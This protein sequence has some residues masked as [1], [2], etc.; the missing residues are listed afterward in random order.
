MPI[1]QLD[2]F[3]FVPYLSARKNLE[4]Y[5]IQRGIKDKSVVDE[6]LYKVGLEK[7]G[8]KS[9]KNFSLG[10]KQRLGIALA[11]MNSP[12]L[13]ILDE[14][15]NGLDPTGIVEVRNLLKDLN[16]NE[17]VTILISS[18]IL[19]ELS[20]IA[21]RY[22][23]INDGK[24]VQ[25]LTKSELDKNCTNKIVLQVGE[26]KKALVVMTRMLNVKNFNIINDNTIEIYDKNLALKD[27]SKAVISNDIELYSLEQKKANLEEYFLDVIGEGDVMRGGGLSA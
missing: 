26:A 7:T 11:L 20:S 8:K 19:T 6:L 2:I 1:I 15:I 16:E 12:K 9:F 18:H 10:M 13:L 22:G 14:P 3:P 27:I 17:G 24:L 21:T 4:Y 5:R 25:E 23:F